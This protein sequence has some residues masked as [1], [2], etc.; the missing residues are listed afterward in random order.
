MHQIVPINTS[1]SQLLRAFF[2]RFKSV[3]SSLEIVFEVFLKMQLLIVAIFLMLHTV[4][5][6]AWY[7][8]RLKNNAPDYLIRFKIYYQPTNVN[9]TLVSGSTCSSPDTVRC[10]YR[11]QWLSP[12]LG[13]ASFIN[14]N[15]T[16]IE[17]R[18]WARPFD[19]MDSFKVLEEFHLKPRNRCMEF[20]GDR[21]NITWKDVPC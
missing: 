13:D 20:E 16:D 12:S 3:S 15:G 10:G 5:T 11:S 14:V 21:S 18:V 19:C 8:I 17:F 6:Q 7:L 4:S 9:S 2:E 1:H